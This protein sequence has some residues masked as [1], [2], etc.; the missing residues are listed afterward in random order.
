MAQLKSTNVTGNLAVTGNINGGKILENGTALS[1]KYA[2]INNTIKSVSFINLGSCPPDAENIDEDGLRCY[3]PEIEI[4]FDNGR[5]YH[6]TCGSFTIPI[7]AG[8]G[9]TIQCDDN[10]RAVISS[11]GGSGGGAGLTLLASGNMPDRQFQLDMTLS[12][13][14]IYLVV[15]KDNSTYA[16]A[17]NAIIKPSIITNSTY[18][19]IAGRAAIIPDTNGHQGVGFVDLTKTPSINCLFTCELCNSIYT[20]INDVI[21]YSDLTYEIYELGGGSGGNSLLVVENTAEAIE[22][23]GGFGY[24]L[25]KYSLVAFEVYAYGK[26]KQ[27]QFFKI[28]KSNIDHLQFD[29]FFFQNDMGANTEAH[30]WLLVEIIS[31]NDTAIL[32]DWSQIGDSVGYGSEDNCVER[33]LFM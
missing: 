31:D 21:N 26:I 4:E 28:D 6:H 11:T 16:W 22:A 10:Y 14:K 5:D 13:E 8:D 3:L 15:I 33:I 20:S 19:E 29:F 12:A 27:S 17:T 9:I 32:S 7:V 1:D 30:T 18:I 2:T 23:A 24:L 25:N